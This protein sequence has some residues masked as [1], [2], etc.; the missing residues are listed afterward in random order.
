ME[1]RFLYLNNQPVD[2]TQV[3]EFVDKVDLN[4]IVIKLQ[5][6]PISEV[7]IDGLQIDDVIIVVKDILRSFQNRFPCEE[8]AE[9]INHL[10]KAK[11]WCDIRTENRKKRN[12]EGTSQA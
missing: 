10:V 3:T 12:V 2:L 6:A 5:S 7:G 1:E 11:E 8:T 9:A 4:H